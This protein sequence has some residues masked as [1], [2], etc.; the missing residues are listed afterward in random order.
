MWYRKEIVF[1]L[2]VK[3][4][5]LWKYWPIVDFCV[6][7]CLC[8]QLVSLLWQSRQ[9]WWHFHNLVQFTQMFAGDALS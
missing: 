6:V 5:I 2:E 7:R 9:N 1:C 4:Y 3:C 8:R